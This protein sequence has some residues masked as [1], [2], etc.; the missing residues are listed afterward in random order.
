MIKNFKI[1]V[2]MCVRNEEENIEKCLKTILKQ[3]D[4]SNIYI[5]DD[6]STD[7]T[8]S[9]ISKYLSDSRIVL[10]KENQQAGLA[11]GLN[12]IIRTSDADYLV[13]HDGDDLMMPNRIAIQSKIAIQNPELDIIS[14]GATYITDDE[15]IDKNEELSDLQIKKKLR[16]CNPIIHPTVMYKR[17]SIICVG[18]YDTK[19]QRAQD[20]ELW[21]RAAQN[22]LKFYRDSRIVTEY[23]YPEKSIAN[24]KKR[25]KSASSKDRKSV[26]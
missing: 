4:I 7:D 11:F 15:D 19:F 20:Y 13:R 12:K 8:C 18:S 6:A 2:A 26:V 1:D 24:K 25:D 14:G 9:I 23:R 21:L 22:N 17:E 10:L 3:N 16:F 5:V